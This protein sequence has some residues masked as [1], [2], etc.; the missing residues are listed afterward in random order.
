MVQVSVSIVANPVLRESG[1]TRFTVV[2][3]S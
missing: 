1:S 2:Y 3:C